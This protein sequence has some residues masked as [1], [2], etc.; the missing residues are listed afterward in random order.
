MAPDPRSLPE[1]L[2]DGIDEMVPLAAGID[3]YTLPTLDDETAALLRRVQ[4]ALV[5]DAV[6]INAQQRID[7]EFRAHIAK[8]PWEI[9]AQVERYW[10]YWMKVAESFLGVYGNEL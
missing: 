1:V 8:Q 4:V 5:D 7:D 6:D 3:D 2:A 9:R 10:L